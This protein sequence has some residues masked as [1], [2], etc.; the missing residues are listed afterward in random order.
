MG[1]NIIK[2]ISRAVGLPDKIGIPLVGALAFPVLAT[3]LAINA[4]ESALKK[5]GG[6]EAILGGH[7]G[8]PAENTMMPNPT[9]TLP[10]YTQQYYVAPTG[11]SDYAPTPSFTPESF[12]QETPPWD[13]STFSPPAPIVQTPSTYPVS[14]AVSSPTS[15]LLSTGADLLGAALPLFL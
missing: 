12:N 1:L 13:Y 11:F 8:Q 7:P 2:A 10:Q 15:D 4:G 3:Q 14:P 6:S 5:F 9:Y